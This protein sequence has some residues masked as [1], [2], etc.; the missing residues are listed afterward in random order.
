MIMLGSGGNGEYDNLIRQPTEIGGS[1][2][3]SP[4]LVVADADAHYAQARSAGAEIIMDIEDQDHGGRAYTCRDPEG[5]IWNF[6]TYD[7]WQ[8]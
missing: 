8:D 3:Q 5:H 6:G 2:T 4:Y 1:V 7:P